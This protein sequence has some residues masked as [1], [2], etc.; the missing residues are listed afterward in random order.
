MKKVPKLRFKPTD[1]GEYPDWEEKTLGEIVEVMQSGVSRLLNDS[2]IGLPVIRSN[3]ISNGNLN[4][5]DIKYWYNIDNQGVDLKNYFLCEGD[6]LVN[7]IN[8]IQQIGKVAI[9]NNLLNRDTI[10]TTNILRL[11]VSKGVHYKFIFNYFQTKKY[12]DY[13]QSITK[14]AVNQASFTTKEFKLFKIFLPS[15]PEQEKIA[16]FLSAVDEKIELRSQKVE[17]LKTYKKAV[18]QKLFSQELRFKSEDGSDYPEWE[19]KT[20]G[21][22]CDIT[23]GSTPDTEIESY[24]GGE[25]LFVSPYDIDKTKVIKNTNK[26]LTPLG[27]EKMRKVKK[28]SVLFVC[29]GSTIGKVGVAS[30]DLTTN[31]QINSLF[32]KEQSND[33]IYYLLNYNSLKIKQLAGEQAVPI[34]NKSE[35]SK[36]FFCFPCLAEQKK[37]ADFLSAIDEK[38]ENNEKVL[39][40]LQSW[41][42]GLLQ[43]MFA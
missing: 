9:F 4:I 36:L 34:I 15:L 11:Q 27:F 13:I 7:F 42:K 33:F 17:K 40:K 26:T 28:D 39:E 16:E 14:P 21:E 10:F 23:T 25:L 32:S 8:S 24:Y 1:G 43:Q 29:I 2:D 30:C 31:Q 3:N 19:E 6:I 38:I 18:M 22:V 37:I 20:L 41:K 35:F 5:S 12:E